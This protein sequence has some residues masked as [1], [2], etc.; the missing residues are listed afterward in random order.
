MY[1]Q[2]LFTSQS[3][4]FKIT[5]LLFTSQSNCFKITFLLCTFF[6]FLNYPHFIHLLFFS[7]KKVILKFVFR[8]VYSLHAKNILNFSSLVLHSF[9]IYIELPFQLYGKE[10]HSNNIYKLKK[11]MISTSFP[12]NSSFTSLNSSFECSYFIV[13]FFLDDFEKWK[14]N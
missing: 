1:I 5:F 13:N 10:K 8:F 6:I 12:I 9:F 4:C 7:L 2:L 14:D 3:N 11:N